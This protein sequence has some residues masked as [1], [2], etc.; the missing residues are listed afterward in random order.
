MLRMSGFQYREIWCLIFISLLFFS[1]IGDA[2][3]NCGSS[4][5]I[6]QI[7]IKSLFYYVMYLDSNTLYTLQ[8][9]NVDASADPVIQ[10]ISLSTNQGVCLRDSGYLGGTETLTIGPSAACTISS[11]GYYAVIAH[12]YGGVDSGGSARFGYQV[13]T[14]PTWYNQ[15]T[16][17]VNGFVWSVNIDP[18]EKIQTSPDIFHGQVDPVVILQQTSTSLALNAND[19]YGL[20]N[21][22][23][24]VQNGSSSISNARVIIGSF[25]SSSEG[26]IKLYR[27]DASDDEPQYPNWTTSNCNVAND[28]DCDGLGNQLELAL[29]SCPCEP[30]ASNCPISSPSGTS[31]KYYDYNKP[32]LLNPRDSDGDGL[33]DYWETFGRPSF[34]ISGVDIILPILLSQFGVNIIHK[35][36]LVEIDYKGDKVVDAS[37]DDMVTVLCR[38]SA[39]NLRNPDGNQGIS[40]HIDGSG[41]TQ[42]TGSC[43]STSGDWG[44][45]NPVTQAHAPNGNMDGN[46]FGVF[47]Y[48]TFGFSDIGAIDWRFSFRSKESPPKGGG[49]GITPKRG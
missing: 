38:G 32:W 12:G 20:L 30:G 36:I 9:D 43:G 21:F 16:I 15:H 39:D 31:C 24:R 1:G 6:C 11:S 7:Q 29:G 5:R 27:N 19:D 14:D 42:K 28:T 44:G 35:D 4:E 8:V 22:Q 46:R 23:S 17:Q 48:S 47:I 18:N 10:V 37:V 45:S 49:F 2:K 25:S 13:G 33:P 26:N 3:A 34:I 41:L 40:L